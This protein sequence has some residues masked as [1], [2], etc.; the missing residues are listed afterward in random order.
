MSGSKIEIINVQTEDN[1]TG[2]VIDDVPHLYWLRIYQAI[3]LNA[4]HAGMVLKRLTPGKHYVTFTR[5]EIKAIFTSIDDL[6]ILP[7]VRSYHFLTVEGYNRAIMEISTGYMNN[8]EI[9][10]AIDAKKDKMAS[11]FTRYEQG[12]VL[13]I[14]DEKAALVGEV[15]HTNGVA[16]ADAKISLYNNARKIAIS[17]G[18]DRRSANIV[19][20]EK[21]KEE[22]PDVHPFMAMIPQGDVKD[23][24]E[25]AVLTR[26]EVADILKIDLNVLEERVVTVGWVMRSVWGW[27]L[28]PKG[29]KFLKPDPHTGE[30][31]TW[32]D[33]RFG[34]DAIR[35]L[36]AEFEQQILT[37]GYF[38][39][40]S[41]KGHLPPLG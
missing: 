11:I 24:P 2:I 3:G 10:A 23:A 17:L 38:S 32:Y 26:Q 41:C 16:L 13:S 12:E 6:S 1:L 30:K 34:L 35:T 28:T 5:S 19:M 27:L 29:S 14:A 18:A 40:G 9:A 25:D 8:P 37:A 20:I 15:A 39:S 36:K 21:I 22:C 7:A 4:D 31:K 33:I